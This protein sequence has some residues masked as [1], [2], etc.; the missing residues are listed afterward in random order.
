MQ[1]PVPGMPLVSLQGVGKVFANGVTA[2]DRLD[3]EIRQ[4][5]FVSLL[6]SSGSG[7]ST[8]LRIIAGLS[9]PTS[10]TVRWGDSAV[11]E[12]IGFVF[13][14]PTLMPWARVFDNVLLPLRLLG[15]SRAEASPR[16][17]DTL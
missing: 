6:G 11:R 17:K 7:K 13:Q 16:V 15:V 1:N 8:A 2:L 10:G 5:E 4:G 14:E 3:L 12:R 9:E